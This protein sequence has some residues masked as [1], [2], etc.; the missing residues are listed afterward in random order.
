MG[1]EGNE[2]GT[3][4]PPTHRRNGAYPKN[5]EDAQDGYQGQHTASNE[6]LAANQKLVKR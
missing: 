3:L 2:F 4:E 1:T 6:D 5:T